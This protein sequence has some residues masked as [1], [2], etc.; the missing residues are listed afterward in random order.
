M[1]RNSIV[2]PPCRNLMNGVTSADLG[3]PDYSLA[4]AQHQAYVR[5]LE[6]CGVKVH[7]VATDELFP[8]CC[9]IEDTALVTRRFAVMT[10]PGAA[11]RR[12]EI[13]AVKGRLGGFFDRIETIDAPGTLDAGDIMMVGDHFFIGRAQRSNEAGAKQCV[14]LLEDQG[15][16]AS[17]VEFSDMLHLKSGLAYLE[18]NNLLACRSCAEMPEFRD[19]D[20]IEVPNDESYAANSIWVN[21][22]V[23]MPAGFP[24]TRAKIVARGYEV[25]EVDTSEYQKLDGGVSCLSLRF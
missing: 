22:M 17:V 2:R 8:D 10:R 1:F 15:F 24:A 6:R 4:L 9:F 5:A 16:T 11:S 12:G 3:R 13:E 25:I 21:N 7:V 23:I 20:I 18:N 19:L 14:A